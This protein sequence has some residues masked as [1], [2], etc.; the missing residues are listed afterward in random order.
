V[1]ASPVDDN[2]CDTFDR[3]TFDHDTFDRT[4]EVI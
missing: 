4:G 1:S 2:R 3:D